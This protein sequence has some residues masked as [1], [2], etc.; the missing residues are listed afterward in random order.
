MGVL[1]NT[2]RSDLLRRRILGPF[3]TAGGAFQAV[4]VIQDFIHL[5]HR[6]G[7]LAH[8]KFI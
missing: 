7:L 5:T 2:L 4:V 3:V 8:K 1:H 6:A